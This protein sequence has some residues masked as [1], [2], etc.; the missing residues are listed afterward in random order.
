MPVAKSVAQLLVE[1]KNGRHVVWAL[2][3]KHNVLQAFTVEIPGEDGGIDALLESVPVRLKMARLRALGI[4]IDADLDIN[5][6]WNRVCHRLTQAGY[7]SLPPS[8]TPGG[9]IIRQKERPDI[10]IWIMPDNTLPGILED[11]VTHLI[12]EAERLAH[13]ANS[14]LD[15]IETESLNQYSLTHR[16]KA[17]IHTWLA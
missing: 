6:Q 16:P 2:C 1:G 7:A 12:P 8:P 15:E 11:F 3:K 5:T 4:L 9:T 10:G 17:F 13:K 14:I